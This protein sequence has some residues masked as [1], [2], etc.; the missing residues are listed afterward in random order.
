MAWMMEEDVRVVP[1]G[2]GDDNGE[3]VQRVTRRGG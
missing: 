3:V 2:S 1:S